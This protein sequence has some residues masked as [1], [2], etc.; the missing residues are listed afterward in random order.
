MRKEF[1]ENMRTSSTKIKELKKKL[2]A[3]M[4]AFDEAS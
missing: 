3:A 2:E 1:A 4:R